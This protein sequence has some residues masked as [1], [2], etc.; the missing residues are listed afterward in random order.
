MRHGMNE[1]GSTLVASVATAVV[2]AGLGASLVTV[3]RSTNLEV[4]QSRY[5]LQ[6]LYLAESAA[7]LAQ[8]S[9][10]NGGSGNFGSSS[11]PVAMGAGAYWTRATKNPDQTIDVIA[12]GVYGGG[13]RAVHLTL[14]GAPTLFDNAIFAGNSSKDPNYK[15]HFGG[16]LTQ[17]DQVKGD[18][19][20]GGDIEVVDQAKL[21]G[22]ARAAGKVT[23]VA[24]EGGIKEPIPDLAAMNYPKIADVDVA[25]AL[26]GKTA[27]NVTGTPGGKAWQVPQ[28]DPAHIFRKNPSDR[29]SMTSGT[30]KDDYFL[31]DPYEKMH[32][33][34]K[35]D[36]SD[37]YF[38]TLS[39]APG[40]PG[41]DGNNKI[42]YVDGN[43]WVNNS[44]AMSFEFNSK[45]PLAITI[46]VRGNIY[47]GDNIF[48]KDAKNDGLALIA[49]KD[50]AVK[51]SGNIYFGD[52]AFGTLEAMN[53]YMYAENNFYDSNLNAAGSA[54]VKLNGMMSAGNQVAINR[55]SKGQHSRLDVTFDSRIAKGS[56]ALPGLPRSQHQGLTFLAWEPGALDH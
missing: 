5:D 9:L 54:I 22:T 21:T 12:N 17:G 19:Y 51:D 39:G 42:Y 18:I 28:S 3:V 33:D 27:T 6:R 48:Y 11:Q 1:S 25:K 36:G 32:T 7:R 24:G 10:S 4:E 43:L 8:N 50:P 41:V 46:V 20:S 37:P 49:M 45:G 29:T 34:S 31:E 52:P 38:V 44:S 16:K 47:V 53:A 23:G 15:M 56:L 2:L 26:S 35:S 13:T 30:V 40:K 14:L 55:D